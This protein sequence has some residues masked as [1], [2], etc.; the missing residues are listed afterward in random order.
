MS[1]LVPPIGWKTQ[2]LDPTIYTVV[3]P[4]LPDWSSGWG[5]YTLRQTFQASALANSGRKYCRVVFRSRPGFTL[6]I[7]SA[8]IGLGAASYGFSGTPTQLKFS[9]ND[10]VTVSGTSTT[11]WA[12]FVIPSSGFMVI[13]L[14]ISSGDTMRSKS[15]TGALVY[16]KNVSDAANVSPSGYGSGYPVCAVDL[17]Q[18]T[19]V[20]D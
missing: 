5:G 16:Y 11:D 20:P 1:I 4:Y 3:D 18:T 13:S 6:V 9:G 2:A 7:A 12:P 19:M 8:Y 17:I 10:G 15:H 14:Y